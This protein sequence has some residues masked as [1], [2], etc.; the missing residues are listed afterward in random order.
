MRSEL[1]GGHSELEM[2]GGTSIMRLLGDTDVARLSSS[3]VC[4]DAESWIFVSELVFRS[5]RNKKK[6][7]LFQNSLE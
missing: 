4:E 2:L 6:R 7:K 3:G 5:P 1:F